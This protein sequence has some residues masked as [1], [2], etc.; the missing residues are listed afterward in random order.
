MILYKALTEPYILLRT[1]EITKM[2]ELRIIHRGSLGKSYKKLVKMGTNKTQGAGC[3]ILQVCKIPAGT[4]FLL[5][6]AP[7]SLW[8]LTRN[9]CVRLRYFVYESTQ[10]FGEFS[11]HK[12]QNSHK[13]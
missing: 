9:F 7:F 12:L 2:Y 13:M 6:S 10:Q 5:F 3:E 1:R 8:L 11:L 4:Q